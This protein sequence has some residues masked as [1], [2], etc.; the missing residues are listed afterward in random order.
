MKMLKNRQCP[1][2]G[3]DCGLGGDME[4]DEEEDGR[5]NENVSICRDFENKKNKKNSNMF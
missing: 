2:F 1:H 4:D 5:V 3:E